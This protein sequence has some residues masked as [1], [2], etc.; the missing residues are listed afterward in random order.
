V[1]YMKSNTGKLLHRRALHQTE[2]SML[3]VCRKWMTFFVSN[4]EAQEGLTVRVRLKPLGYSEEFIKAR[5]LRM[6]E[7]CSE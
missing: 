3:S 7:E 4:G 2:Q 6:C 5:E 1:N